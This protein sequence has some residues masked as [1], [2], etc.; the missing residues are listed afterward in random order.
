MNVGLNLTFSYS[1]KSTPELID[2]S[3]KGEGYI[4]DL[5]INVRADPSATEKGEFQ[6]IFDFIELDVGDFDLFL[7]GNDVSLIINYFSE[8]IKQIIKESLMG[9]LKQQTMKAVEAMVNS[10]LKRL[11]R[12]ADIQDLDLEVDLGLKGKGIVITDDWM[13]IPLEGT[14][15]PIFVS[16]LD[17]ILAE[18]KT[19]IAPIPLH[20]DDGDLV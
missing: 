4:R 17:E 11:P 7:T 16:E 15:H 10:Y 19:Q 20:R 3:G 12:K 1:V 9:H 18:D 5:T 13:A 14:F 8:Q 2:D 6:I